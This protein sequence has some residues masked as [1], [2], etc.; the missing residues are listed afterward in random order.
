MLLESGS[1]ERGVHIL[2][3]CSTAHACL[4]YLDPNEHKGTPSQRPGFLL[5]GS[6]W[7][8]LRIE[9]PKMVGLL[10]VAL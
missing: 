3:G 6:T 2:A 5:Q 8:C 1:E 7:V 10:L 9:E 4:I